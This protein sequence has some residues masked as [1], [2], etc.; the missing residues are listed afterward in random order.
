METLLNLIDRSST[1]MLSVK[2]ISQQ[3]TVAR[4]IINTQ[5]IQIS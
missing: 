2:K 1:A 4:E 5:V 3:H